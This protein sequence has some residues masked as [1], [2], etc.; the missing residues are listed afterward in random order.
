MA[1]KQGLLTLG[2]LLLP[3]AGWAGNTSVY[4][5]QI[6]RL[7][8]PTVEQQKREQSGHVFIYEGLKDKDIE[9]ALDTQ[10]NRIEYMMFVNTIRTDEDGE[11]LIDPDTGEVVTDDGC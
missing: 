9:L 5:W 10:H 6:A 8:T 4:Q 1:V 2:F 3:L 7:M 11:P